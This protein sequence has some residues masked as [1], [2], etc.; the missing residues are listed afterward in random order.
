[1]SAIGGLF[2]LFL[3]LLVVLMIRN[4]YYGGWYDDGFDEETT[5]TT[6]TT[7]TTTV[8]EPQQPE[9]VIVGTLQRL[10][11]TNGQLYVIDP[12]D[13]DKIYV[14]IGDDLYQDGAGQVWQL[15]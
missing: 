11:E 8:V 7:T 14:N 12:V 9:Y 6:T 13:K 10:T 1:M 3:F 2:I 15:S 4:T 5:H